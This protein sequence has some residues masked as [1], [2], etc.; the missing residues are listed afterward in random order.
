MTA[1]GATLRFAANL[2]LLYPEHDFL[3]RYAAAAA[4]GFKGVEMLFPYSWPKEELAGRLREHG[5]EQVLFNAPPGDME[6]GDR[7][8]ASLPGRREEFRS[9][10]E[11]ALEYAQA[12]D[13]RRI[14][15]MAGKHLPAEQARRQHDTYLENL[16]WAASRAATA[17]CTLLIEPINQRDMPGYFLRT[18]AQAHDIVQA[19]GHPNVKVQ[20]DLYHCQISE[21]DIETRLRLYLP[22]GRVGHMQIA[23]VPRRHEPDRGELNYAHVFGVLSE[24]GY[25]GWIGCEYRPA[26]D[27][28]AGLAWLRELLA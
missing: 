3:G 16:D 5:L 23:G 26:G 6:Q 28:R 14:H 21:G 25:D 27:T 24:L 7:G 15:V 12:L 19:L 8:I 17:G 1:K 10:I 13:C 4:D 11:R 18:Q 22:T 9:G 20:M 2:S